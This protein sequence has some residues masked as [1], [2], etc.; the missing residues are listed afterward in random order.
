MLL[1]KTGLLCPWPCDPQVEGHGIGRLFGFE[2]QT[3]IPVL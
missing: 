3:G 2:N 1:F